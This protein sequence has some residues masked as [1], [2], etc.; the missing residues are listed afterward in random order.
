MAT[1][2]TSSQHPRITVDD[3]VWVWLHDAQVWFQL[4]G[5]VEGYCMDPSDMDAH[6]IEHSVMEGLMAKERIVYPYDSES[7][8]EATDE[9]K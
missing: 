5:A 7:D 3:A 8:Y 2:A 6:L 1:S 4:E 9:K